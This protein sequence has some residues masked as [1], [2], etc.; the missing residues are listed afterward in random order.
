[1]TTLAVMKARIAS[2]TTRDDLLDNGAIEA[3]IR[4]AIKFY[5]PSRFWFNE[6]RSTVTFNTVIGQ[7]DYTSAA[8]V[9]IPNLLRIDYVTA[10][11][12]TN[13]V[14]NVTYASPLDMD[15]LI[16]NSPTN[17]SR[18]YRFGYYEGVFR[19]YPIPDAIYPVRIAG[20]IRVAAP[21]TDAETDNAWMV[22]AEELIRARAK[23]NL[24]LNSMLGTET[25]QVSAMK[26]L[27]DEAI[28]RLSRETSSR[29][30]VNFIR[31]DCL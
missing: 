3:E 6:K 8:N 15:I 10:T 25:T 11:W 9:N 27:E 17:S 19:L 12:A 4:S 29:S 31:P 2:E 13:D 18:P 1:M 14:V 28:D 24:Y 21:V 26:Q 22:E 23:R 20:L 5:Q 30:Q 16:F 7:T